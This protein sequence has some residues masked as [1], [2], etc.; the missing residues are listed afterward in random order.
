MTGT[1]RWHKV[2]WRWFGARLFRWTPHAAYAVRRS[3]L[4]AG[5]ASIPSNA[6]FRRSAIIESPWNLTVG[7]RTVVGDDAVLRGPCVISIG[8]RCVVSQ[9]ALVTTTRRDAGD[10]KGPPIQS[11]VTIEDDCWIATDAYVDPG[12][13]VAAGT[14]VGARAVVAGDLPGWMVA[15]GHPA[16]ARA[17]RVLHGEE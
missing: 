3:L 11:A 12:V 6:K 14:V 17:P 16:V 8:A 4:R 7:E 5:G 10:P 1:D 9:Y 2:F 13:C 15:V